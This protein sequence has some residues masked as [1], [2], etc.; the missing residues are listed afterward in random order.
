MNKI[1]SLVLAM[2]VGVISYGQ[3][4]DQIQNKKGIDI[5][6]VKGEFAVG[7]GVGLSNVTGFV[8]SMF[9]YTG[10]NSFNQSYIN[11]PI[12]GT[13]QSIF[14]KYMLTDNN[15]LRMTLYN[16]GS[17]AVTNYE[18][19]DDRANSPDSTVVDK[20]G[21][22]SSTTYISAG[23]E[24]RRGKTRLRGIYGGE[25]VLS[26]SNSSRSYTYGNAMD[27]TNLTP[28]SSIGY[29]NQDYGRILEE[30]FGSTFGIGVRGFVGVEYYIAPKIAMGTEFGWRVMMS[31]SNKSSYTYER[32]DPFADS[33]AGAI[34]THTDTPNLGSRTF[35][36]NIDNFNTQV[37]F[38]FYF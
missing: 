38:H 10:Y 6:P 32:F 3:S 12:V 28:T 27:A 21:S 29:Y 36:S 8:G 13:S 30:N 15:A 35:S 31:K 1:Y 5:M 26:W 20:Y 25:A 7:A 18:V 24:W 34:V 16:G 19:F 23:Y 4:N 14:G 2:C 37:Y 33:G 17:D 22:N 11:S 9:G